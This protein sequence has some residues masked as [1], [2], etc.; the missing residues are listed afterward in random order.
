M[1][2]LLPTIANMFRNTQQVTMTPASTTPMPHPPLS[3]QNPGAANIVPAAGTSNPTIVQAA[4][5]PMAELSTLFQNDPTKQLPIDPLAAPLFNTDPA[6]IAAAAARM[7]FTAQIAPDL[8]AKAMSGDDPA[9]FMQVINQVAQRTLATGMQLNATT[10]EHATTRNN[11][12]VLST[13]PN[14]VKQIQ[15]DSLRPENAMLQHEGAQPMLRL[16]KAQ[17]A[18]KN[19]GMSAV[20]INA[21]AEKALLGFASSVSSTG[22]QAENNAGRGQNNSGEQ[23]DWEAWAG[24]TTDT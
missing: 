11:E 20:D 13:L 14:R 16:L 21:Q 18:M 3:L 8:M 15:L 12:R 23:Q 9:A 19:P 4:S 1:P 6:K 5:D 17:V 24:L 22:N 10:L 2:G 7:D